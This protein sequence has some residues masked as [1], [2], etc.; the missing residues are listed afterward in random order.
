M[1]IDYLGAERSSEYAT[2]IVFSVIDRR[3]RSRKPL[4]I[5]TNLP[6]KAIKEDINPDK[7]RIYDRIL[8]MCTPVYVGGESKRRLSTEKKMQYIKSVFE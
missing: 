1:I 5:T 7:K 2:G 8:D 6:L 4:I 3:W